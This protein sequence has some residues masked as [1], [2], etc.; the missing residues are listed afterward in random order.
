MLAGCTREAAAN[1]LK[2]PDAFHFVPRR[3]AQCHRGYVEK[4]KTPRF[5][6][7]DREVAIGL[8]PWF[9]KAVFERN[10]MRV[11]NVVICQKPHRK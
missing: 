6:T 7:L 2:L 1:V 10:G 4:Y 11:V 9:I 5:Y 3:E 8:Q